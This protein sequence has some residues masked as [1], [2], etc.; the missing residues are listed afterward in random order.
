MLFKKEGGDEYIYKNLN[1]KMFTLLYVRVYTIL[2]M[3]PQEHK[4]NDFGGMKVSLQG[5]VQDY[6]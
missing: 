4:K 5:S 3:I 2:E 6:L 1:V